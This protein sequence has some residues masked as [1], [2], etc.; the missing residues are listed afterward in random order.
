MRSMFILAGSALAL[1]MLTGCAGTLVEP[2]HRGLL[3]DPKGGGLQQ[4]VL[5]PGYY[6]HGIC[7]FSSACPR[8]D[9][10]DVTFSR[11]TEEIQAASVEGLPVTLTL[12]LVYRPIASEL[13][14]LDTEIGPPYYDEVMGP[15]FR[16]SARDVIAHHSYLELNKENQKIED[17]IE[18][19]LRSRT[20]GRH[21]EVSSVLLERAEYAP[22]IKAAVTARLVAAEET[23][24]TKAAMENDSAKRKREMELTAE[25][26]KLATE[27]ESVRAKR[28]IEAKAAT[29][30]LAL[31]TEAAKKKLE[32]ET[33][34]ATKKMELETAAATKKMEIETESMTEEARI[35]LE[36]HRKQSEIELAKEQISVDRLAA[37]AKVEGAKGDA[38]ARIALAKATN[39]ENKAQASLL[40]PMHV[41]MHAY[42]ALA[43]LGGSGTNIMLGDWSHVPSFLFPKTGWASMAPFSVP[44]APMMP[45][46]APAAPAATNETGKD[47]TFASTGK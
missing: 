12:T 7:I 5:Q 40:T 13:Y 8:V 36:L 2:G 39:E 30:K 18:A 22:E 32:L 29:D 34:A 10:F 47:D 43:H 11:R 25:Q 19:E 20:K 45:Q 24:R 23:T 44:W 4:G 14:Q 6:R 9:D 37:Q 35:K 17:D 33:D 31:E 21:V 16:S 26:Q 1:S 38:G 42:D 27:N 41:M 15:E 46:Q 28:D 3:F